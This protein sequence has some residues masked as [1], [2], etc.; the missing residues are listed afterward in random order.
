MNSIKELY[1][2]DNYGELIENLW[3]QLK[4]EGENI[5]RVEVS[6]YLNELK[7]NLQKKKENSFLP[8]VVKGKAKQLE[9][10]GLINLTDMKT[11]INEFYGT[12]VEYLD[13][14]SGNLQNLQH[15]Q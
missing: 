4:I 6:N 5:S 11:I 1:I 14:W 9:Q 13:Q 10:D 8:L 7:E 12:C 2:K 15:M 3:L